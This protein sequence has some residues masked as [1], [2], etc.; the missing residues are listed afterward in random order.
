MRAAI[1]RITA[2]LLLD[3]L[4]LPPGTV[5]HDAR[6]AFES[7]D[8]QLVLEHPSL[9]VVQPGELFPRA[10]VEYTAAAAGPQSFLEFR[11]IG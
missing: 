4:K 1:V 10:Q 6:M 8:L 3:A 5:L 11:V 7:Y 9:P 2:D